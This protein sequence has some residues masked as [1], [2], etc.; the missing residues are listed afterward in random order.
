MARFGLQVTCA[1]SL[2]ALGAVAEGQ[3]NFT[4]GAN[5]QGST[6]NSSG[7]IPP[8]TCGAIGPEHFVEL[9]NGQYA[10]Y[11]RGGGLLFTSDLNGFFE[12]A[13]VDPLGPF[14]FDPRVL[15]DPESGRWF[16][17]AVDNGGLPNNVL[18]AVSNSANPLDGWQGLAIDSDSTDG[19]WADFPTMGLDTN[20]LYIAANMFPVYEAGAR[21]HLLILPKGDLLLDPPSA[22]NAKLFENILWS[23]FGFSVQPAVSLDGPSDTLPM[24]SE[25]FLEDSEIGVTTLFGPLDF[26]SF[27]LPP[28]PI[29]VTP[30]AWADSYYGIP[31][32]DAV[33]PAL[34]SQKQA[35]DASDHRFSSNAVLVGGVLWAVHTINGPIGATLQWVKID[36]ATN[37]LI[38]EGIIEHPTLRFYYGSIAAN[39]FGN[40]VIGCSASSE[41]QAVSC[42]AF[43]G[44]TA[45]N[46]TTFEG[47]WLLRA[48]Q[49]DY[50]LLD[51][52]GRNR[53]GDYSA[54]TLD[55]TDPKRFWTIQEFVLD[56]DVWATNVTEIVFDELNCK[57]DLNGDGAANIFDFV[58]FQVL[59]NFEDVVA[60]CNADGVFNVFDFVCYQ[61]EF[62]G[63][64]P[65]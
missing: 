35:L 5:F 33:Q 51:G 19:R 17:C 14:A 49:D 29:E 1:A 10:V 3:D 27:G 6:L 12:A 13:G 28:T 36:A 20:G 41:T 38:Q 7:F 16:A 24:L 30:F 37:T 58:A 56:D 64:C 55:P 62:Q 59:F 9:I 8:D 57:A 31:V 4:L 63:G 25:F 48:G 44:K 43:T 11:T 21:V 15:Y 2:L 54:T 42:Y 26:P 32:P 52:I 65:E 18:V 22:E 53:W 39:E 45:L 60:D 46:H 23:D 61:V 47:P 50:Q 40:V 34:P